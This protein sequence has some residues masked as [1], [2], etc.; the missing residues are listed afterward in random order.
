MIR[1]KVAKRWPGFTLVELL[2]VIA[3]IGIL[4]ALLLPAVQAARE[5]ARRSQCSNNLKQL[6][7]ALHNYHDTFRIFPHGTKFYDPANVPTAAPW[8]A[9][10][11][12]KG[13]M[14]VKLLP[15]M[16]QDPLHAQLDFTIDIFTQ[17]TALGYGSGGGVT[18]KQVD[19]L[20]CPSDTYMPNATMSNY[21]KSMGFQPMPG[22]DTVCTQY[23]SPNVTYFHT[24]MPGHG[25]NASNTTTSGCFSR[26]Q[27]AAMLRDVTDGTSNTILM[28]ETRPFCGDHH[29]H[30]GFENNSLWTATTSPINYA[31]CPGEGLGTDTGAYSCNHFGNW[32]TSQ[33]FK[34]MHPGGAQFLLADGSTQFLSET[35]DYYTY[36]RLGDRW[37][38]QPVGNF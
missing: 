11:H 22:R 17:L 24:G 25:S 33:G 14:L 28:G 27:W 29:R 37:D 31:T 1:L 10:D 19:G 13:S 18:H 36:Q 16:E 6:G 21:G 15:F 35:I 2:V 8:T 26:A 38:G 30:S 9:G 23:Q 20:R 32:Q 34:S 4:I 3:I 7:L 12:D 5:A